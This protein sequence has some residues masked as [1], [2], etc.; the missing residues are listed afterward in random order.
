MNKNVEKQIALL[1]EKM[2]ELNREIEN[3]GTSCL[4]PRCIDTLSRF[5]EPNTMEQGGLWGL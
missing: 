1:S 2:K 4:H 5:S 3:S